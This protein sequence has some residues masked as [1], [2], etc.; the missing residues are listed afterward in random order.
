MF[1]ASPLI[2][3]PD[4]VVLKGRTE[5]RNC[6]VHARYLRFNDKFAFKNSGQEAKV[7]CKARSEA[8]EKVSGVNSVDMPTFLSL[9][10]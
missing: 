10:S 8:A 7:A 2:V 3:V 9:D 4:T 5:R 1:E 6:K